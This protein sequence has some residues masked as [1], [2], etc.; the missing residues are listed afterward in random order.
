MSK[1]YGFGIKSRTEPE[2]RGWVRKDFTL[3]E[4]LERARADA[5]MANR[6]LLLAES[7]LIRALSEANEAKELVARLE[8][9]IDADEHEQG[10]FGA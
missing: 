9:E 1:L 10:G 3:Q 4:R 7:A 6:K 5:G 2:R 8:V